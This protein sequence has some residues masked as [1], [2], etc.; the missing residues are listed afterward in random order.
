MTGEQKFEQ[1]TTTS[2]NKKNIHIFLERKKKE[3]IE[4]NKINLI[5]KRKIADE[6]NNKLEQLQKTTKELAKASVRKKVYKRDVSYLILNLL[7]KS[8]LGITCTYLLYLYFLI[9]LIY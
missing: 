7:F 4:K 6:R 2:T 3:R 1:S 5:E 9:Y 8:T